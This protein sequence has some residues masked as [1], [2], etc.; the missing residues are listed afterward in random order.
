MTHKRSLL[1]F[2]ISV[3]LVTGTSYAA[4]NLG[5]ISVTATRLETPVDEI[6]ASV[7]VV[8]EN[9]I[10]FAR[11]QVG[12]D[13]SLAAVPGLFMQNR[14]NFAQDLRVS[15]RGFGARSS[16][17]IRGIK[18]LVD[19]IPETL[20]DGQG[21]IDSID[22]GSMARMSVIRGPSSALYGNAAGGAIIIETE[23]ASKTPF[24]SLRPSWGE[25]GFQKHQLKTGGTSGKLGYL[26]NLS[27]LDYD[28]YRDHSA[29]ELNNVNSKF[30]YEI[31]DKSN[32]TTVLNYT[33]SPKADDPGGVNLETFKNDPTAAR[34]RNVDLDTGESTEQTRLGFIYKRSIGQGELQVRNYYTWKDFLGR[35]PVADSGVIA[36][37]R[38]V[39]GGGAQYTQNGLLAGKANRFTVGLDIDEQD[40]DRTRNANNNGVAGDLTLKQNENVS[41]T[42]VFI[43]NETTLNESMIITVGGRYDR[44]T[45]DVTDKFLNDGDD[46]GKRTLDQFSPSLGVLFK[47]NQ[48][49]NV[50]ATASTGFKTPTTTQFANPNGGGFN[51]DLDPEEST[52]LE[53][54]VKGL[55]GQHSRYEL[56]LFNINVD[57][58][59]I[60]YEV[61]GRDVFENAGSSKRRGIEAALSSEPVDGMITTLAYT[62]NDFEFDEFVSDGDDFGGNTTP[63]VPEQIVHASI[64]YTHPSSAFIKLDWMYVGEMYANNSNSVEVDRYDVANLQLGYSKLMGQWEFSP[65]LGINNLTDELYPSNIRINAFG[66]RYYEAAPERNA[67]GGFTLRYDFQ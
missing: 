61:D 39:Y 47:L 8:D 65:F 2:C 16:F 54:G 59:L 34:D 44:V 5:E 37:D 57:D 46:S 50:F 55:I 67:Y 31:D 20:P 21:N 41:S 24:I 28:G 64:G 32:L 25:D 12:I 18:I 36:Y 48:Q 3:A 58:E 52:N 63:G 11:Q 45:F 66:G 22:I 53:V 27:T 42:G 30:S 19:G 33:D 56:A 13:E 51:P 1:S 38:F 10:Q 6:P 15:I 43:S 60:G 4:D 9:D 26:L 17:G 23:D 14:F 49:T 7:S 62:R 40:D 35:V 29:T